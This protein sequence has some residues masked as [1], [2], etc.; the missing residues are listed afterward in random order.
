MKI[1]VLTATLS[2][3]SLTN[4]FTIAGHRQLSLTSTSRLSLSS[5][6]ESDFGS[7]MTDL[8]ETSPYEKLGI[9]ESQLALGVDP[10]EVYKYI[11]T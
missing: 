8:T 2:L 11:G 10:A 3:L 5:V 9:D 1:A 6:M 4:G 7:A